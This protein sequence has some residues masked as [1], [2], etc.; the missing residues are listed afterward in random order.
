M[1]MGPYLGVN[2]RLLFVYQTKYHNFCTHTRYLYVG[3]HLSAINPTFPPPP[4]SH[5]PL[6]R[7]LTIEDDAISMLN[8]SLS[9]KLSQLCTPYPVRPVLGDFTQ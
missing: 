6:T 2:T 1:Q 5:V 9:F 8:V 3:I 4:P 7:V